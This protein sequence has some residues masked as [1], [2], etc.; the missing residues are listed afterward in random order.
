MKLI[1]WNVNGLRS[2]LKK[3]AL[4]D[5]FALDA[6]I[7]C[8]QETKASL[9][10]IPELELMY[11][12]YRYF[13]AASKKG[14]SGTAILSKIEPIKVTIEFPETKNAHPNEGRL[15]TAEFDTFYLINVYV[16]NSKRELL[17]L[18]YRNTEWDP[19]L[20]NYIQNLAK[21]KPVIICGD[22]NVAHEEID[23]A[24]PKSNH[25]NAGFTDQERNNFSKLLESGFVDT[26]R[27]FH[28][29]ES[30]HYTWWTPKADARMRNIGWRID[31]FLTSKNLE[32]KLN[33][34]KIHTNYY[35]SD[36]APIELEISF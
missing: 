3:G 1:S 19:D 18:P 16:P 23:I 8:L 22:F 31:Y 25:F 26:F 12:S 11:Y 7:I 6:D 21:K 24:N 29:G 20:R 10:V 2:V 34:V 28:P 17:R 27:H 14:Y 13:H 9:D 35:G 32:Q 30:G 36:H 4:H 5:V 15:Q 33:S